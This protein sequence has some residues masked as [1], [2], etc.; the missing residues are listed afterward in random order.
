ATDSGGVHA[1]CRSS[2]WVTNSDN[3]NGPKAKFCCALSNPAF[4]PS[5]DIVMRLAPANT[6]LVNARD[7]LN[8]G[9]V[10][11][12]YL[13]PAGNMAPPPDLRDDIDTPAFVLISHGRNRSGAYVVNGTADRIPFDLGGSNNLFEKRNQDGDR[14]YYTGP[15]NEARGRNYFDD[16][17]VWRT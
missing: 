6:V 9:A 7:V 3:A 15:R 13:D 1:L 5:E 14:T 2:R 4:P 8:Y 16:I 10:N 11:Q 17:V 12:Q